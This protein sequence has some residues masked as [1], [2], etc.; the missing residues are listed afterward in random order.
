MH[1]ILLLRAAFIFFGCVCWGS[2]YFCWKD[3]LLNELDRF[4]LNNL[5]GHLANWILPNSSSAWKI[6]F[7]LFFL[8]AMPLVLW[9]LCI[10]FMTQEMFLQ[11][12]QHQYGFC[13]MVELV[14]VLVCGFGEG[15]LSRPW[16]KIWHQSHLL[17][18]LVKHLRLMLIFLGC[19]ICVV[20]PHESSANVTQAWIISW[21]SSHCCELFRFYILS[22]P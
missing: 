10:W 2:I 6:I 18:K 7:V 12:W 22:C 13:S 8:S 19:I 5:V 15:E 16:G 14:F 20:L 21:C 1:G 3:C 4:A 17:G 11:K 9:L